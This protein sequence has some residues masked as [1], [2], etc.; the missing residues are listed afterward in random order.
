MVWPLASKIMTVPSRLLTSSGTTSC[1][2]PAASPAATARSTPSVLANRRMDGGVQRRVLGV[3]KLV[4]DP[5]LQR[6]RDQA[7]GQIGSHHPK[8]QHQEEER[9][10]DLGPDPQPR[11]E[12]EASRQA[13]PLYNRWAAGMLHTFHLG[14]PPLPSPVVRVPERAQP[15]WLLFWQLNDLAATPGAVG[16]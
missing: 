8:N 1:R 14:C 10:D 15:P 2:N 6:G 5:V 7:G 12:R 13:H 3:R 9:Q 11:A 16:V 4:R